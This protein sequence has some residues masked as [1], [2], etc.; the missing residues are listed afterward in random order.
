[1]PS[2]FTRLLLYGSLLLF[3]PLPGKGQ[4]NALE[5]PGNNID[6]DC[7]GLDDIFLHLP[8]YIYLAPE[9]PYELFFRH[10]ILSGRP[11]D[12]FF[13]LST[14][15]GGIVEAEKWTIT[16]TKEQ[17]GE[18]PLLLV[19]RTPK[20]KMVARARTTIRVSK[21]GLPEDN[22]T[23]KGLVI[24][25]SFIDQGYLPYYL[26]ELLLQE[27]NPAI[28]F[29]G[30]R[31][32]WIDSQLRF[33]AAGGTSWGYYSSNAQSPMYYDGRL[34]LRSYF[35]TV[36]GPGQNPDWIIIHL[37]VADYCM[38]GFLDG[39]SVT[40]IDD[41]IA[42]T[43]E[44]YTR[45][46]ID[47]IRAVA[48]A[49]KIGISNTPYPSA[50]QPAFDYAY[51]VNGA[52]SSRFRWKLIVSRLLFK[53]SE[54]FAQRE[55]ENIYLLPAHLNLDEVNEYSLTD[56]L[57]PHPGPNLAGP[58]GYRRIART[59][60]A[61]LRYLMVGTTQADLSPLISSV[62]SA[63]PGSDFQIFPNPTTG[64]AVVERSNPSDD[65]A[66][67]TVFNAAGQVILEKTWAADISNR[68]ALDLRGL[69]AGPYLLRIARSDQNAV[70]KRLIVA[71]H[72]P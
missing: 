13:E 65:P 25:H 19:V 34:N 4:C 44:A 8:P 42:S 15:L 71:P 50:S 21:A 10:T 45:P 58:S 69:P 52:L 56:P 16:P 18:Y 35:D 63:S 72:S 41:Y 32:S 5:I 36:V 64:H 51:G 14:P 31:H 66:Q 28:T 27:G 60:Y 53:N 46:L 11:A 24:G 49:A 59:Y 62:S 26:R 1:M 7:D 61:W 54:F 70:F 67:V 37:D 38:A 29:H 2:L 22:S 48:P 40:A 23:R 39:S 47:S 68:L 9:E 33:E 55:A 17:A 12:Y 43:Y 30:K 6:E 20:G 57:H 3:V